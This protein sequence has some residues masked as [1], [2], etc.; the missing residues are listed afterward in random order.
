MSFVPILILLWLV[1]LI[2]KPSYE[3]IIAGIVSG[4]TIAIHDFIIEYYAYKRGLWYCY[5]GFQQVGKYN[6][7]VPIDMS[8]L[9]FIGGFVLGNFSIFP[10]YIREHGLIIDPI[11]TSPYLDIVWIF[12]ALIIL[13]FIGAGMDFLSKKFGVW[14]NGRTWTYWKCAIYAWFPLLAFSVIMNYLTLILI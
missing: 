1:M 7:H 2:F 10:I 9:F 13:A 12:L 5:G 11:I 3:N 14:E 8:V 6:L 4:V